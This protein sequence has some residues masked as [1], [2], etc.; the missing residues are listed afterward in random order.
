MVEVTTMP[1]PA[2]ADY[3]EAFREDGV[4]CIPRALGA[5]DLRLIEAAYQWRLD[6]LDVD[7]CNIAAADTG[8][9]FLA[10]P[11]D[12]SAEPAFRAML[13]DTAVGDIALALFGDG[14]VWYLEEQLFYKE[15]GSAP[16]GAARTAWH[17]DASYYPY[18]G[19]KH[20]VFWVPLDPVPQDCALEIVR[21]SHRS[22][23]LYRT[24]RFDPHDDSAPL[25]AHTT[26][27]PAPA[28]EAE[29]DRWDIV[30]WAL[31]PGDLLVFHPAALHGGGAT[32]PGGRRRSLTLRLGGDDVVRIAD[33]DGDGPAQPFLERYWALPLGAPVADAGAARIRPWS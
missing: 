26:L 8:A 11:G 31:E 21:G 24:P 6:T 22:G 14:P 15:A 4:V 1:R 3:A 33:P 5:E 32:H 19:A 23:M 12:S 10:I 13:R 28:I 25:H 2:F 16:E 30:S 9:T 29:R 18:R 27:P 17:H 7:T 20:A